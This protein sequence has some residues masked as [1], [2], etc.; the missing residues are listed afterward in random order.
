MNG[1]SI[2]ISDSIFKNEELINDL[3]NFFK[4]LKEYPKIQT[5]LSIENLEKIKL[6]DLDFK[7]VKSFYF[8]YLNLG[9]NENE[10]EYLNKIF[11]LLEGNNVLQVLT[12]I[13]FKPISLKPESIKMINNFMNLKYILLINV[14]LEDIFT[15]KLANLN[16][17]LIANCKNIAFDDDIIYNIETLSIYSSEIIKPKSLL[18]FPEIKNFLTDSLDIIS[19]I[20]LNYAKKLRNVSSKLSNCIKLDIPF[21]ESLVLEGCRDINNEIEKIAVERILD[22]DNLNHITLKIDL[23]DEQIAKI[24]KSN[25]SVKS[26]TFQNIKNI[27]NNFLEKFPNLKEFEYS[28]QQQ[29]TENNYFEIKENKYS[30]IEKITLEEIPNGILYCQPFENIKSLNFTF[31]NKINNI[32]KIFPLF[33][34]KCN[35]MFKSLIDFSLTYDNINDEFLNI[36]KTNFVC[37]PYLLNFSLIMSINNISKNCYY[38]FIKIVLLK[39]INNISIKLKTLDDSTLPNLAK[40]EIKD[41]CCN[42]NFTYHGNVE[43]SKYIKEINFNN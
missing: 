32:E 39:N 33:K 17:L 43:I 29:N 7:K 1:F 18:K 9:N 8:N 23:N 20:D 34:D 14:Q 36:L 25:L 5:I 3:R 2:T 35:I 26:I 12:S 16:A 19:F 40:Q 10:N 24:K 21:L 42:F 37:I 22:F 15:I 13:L 30:K 28:A 31:H 6:L 4:N 11:S 38:D 41:I 27:V